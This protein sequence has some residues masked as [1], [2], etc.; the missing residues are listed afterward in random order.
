MTFLNSYQ[1]LITYDPKTPED[2][3]LKNLSILIPYDQKT[4]AD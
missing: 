1:A 3:W 4:H 2:W